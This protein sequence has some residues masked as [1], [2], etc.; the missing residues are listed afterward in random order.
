[1]RCSKF[2]LFRLLNLLVILSISSTTINAQFTSIQG[3]LIDET[4]GD[5]LPFGSVQFPEIKLG[6][7]SDNDGNFLIETKR[8]VTILR[9]TYLGYETKEIP[10]KPGST[11]GL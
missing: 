3:K 9:V 5:P 7:Y 10:I 8:D 2:G 11:K 4:S 6:V 1:M